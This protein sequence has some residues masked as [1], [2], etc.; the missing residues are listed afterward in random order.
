HRNHPGR[1]GDLRSRRARRAHRIERES[2]LRSHHAGLR[3]IHACAFTTGRQARLRIDEFGRLFGAADGVRVFRA[4]GRVNL[5]GEHTDY[6]LGFVLPMAL[7]LATTIS[8]S[9]S[10]GAKLRAYSEG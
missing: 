2:L 3:C 6:N 5:I 4:P 1:Y 10:A 8:T 7:D 9:R